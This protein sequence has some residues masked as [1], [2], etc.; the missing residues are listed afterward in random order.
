MSQM[1]L[2]MLNAQKKLT[3][4]CEWLQSSLIHTYEQAKRLMPVPSLD[5]VVKAGTF[6]IPEKG[7]LGYCPEAGLVYITV[8]PEN[9]LF[10]KNEA[11]SVERMFAHELHHAARWAGPGYGSSLGEVI[12][13]EGLAGHFSLELF[14]GEP[15]PWESLTSDILPSCRPLLLENWHRTDYDH[16]AW[17][18]GT[19]KLPR[20]LGYTAGF[21]LICRYLT[22]Y[23]HLKASMLADMNAEE[24]KTFV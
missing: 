13:S 11:H 18:F 23:P 2:H 8:D 6:V 5:V 19:G 22:Y 16:N 17:F 24:L 1:T 12:V 10:C 20:W 4:H 21:N 7:H 15:E 14:G 9:P 3:A